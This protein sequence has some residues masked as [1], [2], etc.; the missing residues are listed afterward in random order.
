[1]SLRITEVKGIGESTAKAL[2]DHGFDSAQSLAVA[3]IADIVAVPGFG[4]RRASSVS[5]AARAAISETIPPGPDVDRE[6]EIVASAAVEKTISNKKG[7]K[8][9]KSKK[10]KKSKKAKKIMKNKKTKTKTKKGK[11]VQAKKKGKK[12]KK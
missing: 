1:M 10:S 9:M 2:A 11:K 6:T 5:E 8:T 4:P 12:S 7:K 3:A